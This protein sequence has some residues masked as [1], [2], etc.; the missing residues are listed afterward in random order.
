LRSLYVDAQAN[1]LWLRAY[2]AASSQP[3][4]PELVF[5]FIDRDGRDDTGGAARGADLHP[6]LADDPSEGGYEFAVGVRGDA[7]LEGV[8]Q[9]DPALRKWVEISDYPPADLRTELGVAVDPL[10]IGAADHGYFQ[11]TVAHDL[12]GLTQSCG[13]TIFVRLLSDGSP[14][15][16]FADDAPDEIPCQ[17]ANDAY[18]DPAVLR[19]DGCSS[20]AECPAD[21]ICREHICLF[22]Y[23]CTRAADC[24]SDERCSDGQ[25]VRVVTGGCTDAED[26]AGLV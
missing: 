26:C 23:P 22:A 4:G 13:G 11:L 8:F 6:A 19:P 16:S 21:G 3:A 18:G 1:A 2:V 15:R 5:F 14:R 12:S 17:S 25:C 7:S 20:D 24:R 10:A 9:W